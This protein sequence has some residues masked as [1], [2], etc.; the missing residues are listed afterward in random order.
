M[1]VTMIVQ[2]CAVLLA[3]GV[4]GYTIMR[5][6]NIQMLY[7]TG[8]TLCVALYALGTLFEMSATTPDAAL[9]GLKLEYIGVPFLGVFFYLFSR[10]YCGSAWRNRGYIA[11]L[12]LFPL[13][14]ALMVF[15]WPASTL[16]YQGFTFEAA[17]GIGHLARMAGPLYYVGLA[18]NYG[19]ALLGIIMM[20]RYFFRTRL[21]GAMHHFWAFLACAAAIFAAQLVQLF[22][23]LPGGF[24]P[25]SAVLAVCAALLEW[26]LL[27]YRSREW[28]SLGRESVV[29]KMKDAF[30]L[31]DI[32]GRFLDANAM[33]YHYFPE[34][35]HLGAGL[36]ITKVA[37]FPAELLAQQESDYE[38]TIGHKDSPTYLR[39]SQS[40]LEFDGRVLGNCIIIYD[41]TEKHRLLEELQQLAT[42]DA[43]T[44]LLNRGTFF[45]HAQR[46]FDLAHRCKDNASVLM[47]DIDHFKLVN[48]VHGHPCGDR[49]L[50]EIAGLLVSR[51][52][53]TDIS[54]RYGGEEITV[55]LPGAP[56]EGAAIIA[57][58]IR[59]AV[60]STPF[61]SDIGPFQVTVS[62][63]VCGLAH[64][65]HGTLEAMICDADEALYSAKR[66]G[67]NRVCVHCPP[68]LEFTKQ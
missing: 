67:R 9:V 10:D 7:Y 32:R 22:A 43:L 35:S 30:I 61:E 28:A 34:L 16:F 41:I 60:E 1:V 58:V 44:G 4:A 38:F 36:P 29:E 25:V 12:M 39:A 13:L 14:Q 3:V 42:Q 64:A 47:L 15:T 54:G 50:S 55:W 11:A 63:G 18:Y 20:M 17:G 37:G 40:P 51:L 24:S 33:A 52:R 23:L 57:D 2:S 49:V 65:R 45:T 62:I 66:E 26:H 6:C 59:R 46:D 21:T 5:Q 8:F 68:V 27:R 31:L 53:H 48:D 19:L 56:A